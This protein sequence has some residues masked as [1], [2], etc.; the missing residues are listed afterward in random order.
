VRIVTVIAMNL[1]PVFDQLVATF[2][3]NVMPALQQILARFQQ[4]QPTIQRV[5]SVI[6]MLVG[7][8]LEFAAAVLGRVLPVVIRFAGFLLSKLVPAI[9]NSIEFVARFIGAVIKIGAAF[10][11]AIASVAKFYIAVYKKIGQ[12]LKV[13]A[14]IPGKVVSA[15]GDLSTTLYHSGIALL[16]GF[17]QGIADKARDVYNAAKDALSKIKNLFPHSPAKEG[18]FSGRGWV[19]Y[20]G[21]SISE[22]LAKGIS[23]KAPK[24]VK[25]AFHLVSKIK[26]ADRHSQGLVRLSS[27]LDREFV[28][29]ACST[30]AVTQ[31]GG[32]SRHVPAGLLGKQRRSHRQGSSALNAAFKKLV[33]EGLSPT[34]LSTC[35]SRATRT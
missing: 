9:L 22:A 4:W 8:V 30:A 16:A 3:A 20:S 25:A 35:S 23:D 24:A 2:R 14:E 11:G 28:H 21:H 7:H 13:V 6:L 34:F 5:A 33:R 32:R 17:G 31:N 29:G 19:L 26:S 10:V 15:L 27:V 12:V 1:K 18:P